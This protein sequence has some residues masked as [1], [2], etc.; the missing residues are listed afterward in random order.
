MVRVTLTTSVQLTARFDMDVSEFYSIG[1]QTLFI[2]RMCALLDI[3]D[4]SRFKVVG[5]YAGSVI[6]DSVID[7]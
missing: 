5:V 7:V 2:N 1:G 3:T 4:T 6:V